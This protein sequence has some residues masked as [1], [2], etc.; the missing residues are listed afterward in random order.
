[1]K[2]AVR[3]IEGGAGGARREAEIETSD[4]RGSGRQVASI[5]LILALI[6]AKCIDPAAGLTSLSTASGLYGVGPAP[7]SSAGAVSG[8]PGAR[9]SGGRLSPF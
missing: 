5:S 2:R 1:M 3:E 9:P 7:P 4:V 8:G 6:A